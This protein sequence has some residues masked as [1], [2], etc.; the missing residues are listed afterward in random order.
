MTP[1]HDECP[2]CKAADRLHGSLLEELEALTSVRPPPGTEMAH[3]LQALAE[4]V[5]AYEQISWPHC[6]PNDETKEEEVG[7]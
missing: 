6:R 2:V 5:A 4:L 3:R 7:T 1:G